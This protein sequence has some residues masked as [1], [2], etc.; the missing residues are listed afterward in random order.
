MDK[1]EFNF[2]KIVDDS[3][4]VLLSSKEYF[5]SMK[6]KGGLLEPIITAVL[7]G[8]AGTII[9]F[10][11][12]LLGI[13]ALGSGYGISF[14]SFIII[15]LYA[16]IGLFIG[17]VILVVLSAISNGNTDYEANIRV[18]AA[19][20]VLFPVNAF[21]GF[22]YGFGIFFGAV[23]A[24]LVA[25]YG[26]WMLYNA[27]IFAL[28]GKESIVKILSM[29]IGIIPVIAILSSLICYK[30]VSTISD[31]IIRGLPTDNKEVQE[32]TKEALENYMKGLEKKE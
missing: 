24:V 4:S 1:F 9:M 3:K 32:K 29:V 7:Y 27:L 11:W 17:G 2:Q 20:M 23:I 21:F 25:L 28:E 30:T 22:A 13:N 5:S 31:E 8:L 15:P 12:S 14:A 26:I 10:I 19:L 18:S 6:K 16:F